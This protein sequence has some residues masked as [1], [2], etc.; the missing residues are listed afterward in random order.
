MSEIRESCDG[1]AHYLGGGHCEIGLEYE[2]R[3]GGGFEAYRPGKSENEPDFPICQI[4]ICE[5]PKPEEPGLHRTE[6][7]RFASWFCI[8]CCAACS[9]IVLIRLIRG[10]LF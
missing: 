3:E 10:D 9:L 2:C 8:L 4:Y 6:T 5:T 7:E 1:C